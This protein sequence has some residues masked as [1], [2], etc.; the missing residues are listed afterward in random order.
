MEFSVFQKVA[1]YLKFLWRVLVFV[2]VILVF[3][4]LHIVNRLY[5]HII[6]FFSFKVK[7]IILDA[8]AF[9]S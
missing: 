2:F 6:Q 7:L 8:M 3:Y 1:R 9:K 4:E 5:Q